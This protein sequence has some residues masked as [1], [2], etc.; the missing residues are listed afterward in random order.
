MEGGLG[1]LFG[2]ENGQFLRFA[3]LGRAQVGMPG[4]GSLPVGTYGRATT[5]GWRGLYAG[6]SDDGRRLV[7]GCTLRSG[8]CSVCAVIETVM[9]PLCSM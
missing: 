3:D 2:R 4:L 6:Q 7:S 1:L 5:T 9:V 8:C